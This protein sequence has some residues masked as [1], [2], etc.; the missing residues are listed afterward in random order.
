MNYYFDETLNHKENGS[1]KWEQPEGMDDCIGMGTADLD[2]F[3]PPCVKDACLSVALDNTYN[4]RAKPEQ[5][6]QTVIHWYK[7][8]YDCEI[9]KEWLY[10]VPSTIGA[11]RIVLETL[12]KPGNKVLIQTPAFI[13]LVWA[14]EG[15]GCSK[16]ENPL[17]YRDN[18][19]IVDFEDFERKIKDNHPSV[20]LLVNPHNP[21]GKVFTHEELEKM[22][23]ICHKYGVRIISDEVH[24]L[25]T[26]P[27]HKHI[28]ILAVSKKAQDISV[29]IVSMSKG[30]NMMSLPHAIVIVADEELRKRYEKEVI[31]YSFHYAVN[32]FSITAVTA[33]LSGAADEWLCDVTEYLWDNI[34]QVKNILER[35]LPGVRVICPEGGYLVWIDLGCYTV[36]EGGWG[37]F[38]L[39]RA[40]V[41]LN[42]GEE[43]GIEYK[44]FIRMNVGLRKT[45][46]KEA[47]RRIICSI[48]KK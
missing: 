47:L 12:T 32:S 17:V 43:F 22:V 15:V 23:N 25:I 35:E 11:I 44:N 31:P 39:K 20:F 18:Q 30:F 36:P 16:L 2:F 27:G 41:S 40:H 4:Y 3:C 6:Y 37:K 8:M 24:S 34:L 46:L 9:K 48:V 10:N 38:I 26:F 5:Y 21:M 14:I 28:P 45:D 33:V 7:R 19:Y 42:D 13:P 29:Q 1:Y